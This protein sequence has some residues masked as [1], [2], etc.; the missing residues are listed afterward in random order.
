MLRPRHV[1]I[2]PLTL[3]ILGGLLL[4][5]TVP[6]LGSETTD[7]REV[8]GETG[9]SAV[10]TPARFATPATVATVQ[11]AIRVALALRELADEL[12]PPSYRLPVDAAVVRPFEPPSTEYGPG[13][14][15]VDLDA[16]PGSSVRAAERGRVRHAGQVAGYH[17]PTST[18][19]G[20]YHQA[21]T[22]ACPKLRTT[23]P[24][25]SPCQ[26]PM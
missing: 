12:R 15:G 13:H 6:V 26:Q 21:M 7:R 22:E 2:R 17:C 24:R 8:R 16:K 18:L 1:R 11:S 10:T 19:G 14:R 3:L 25:R 23:Q 9:R 4:V 20:R 5:L